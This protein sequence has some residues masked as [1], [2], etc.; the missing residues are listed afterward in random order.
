MPRRQIILANEEIYHVFNKGVADLP[1]FRDQYDYRRIIELVNFYRFQKPPSRYSFF[2]RLPKNTKNEI[3]S[4]LQKTNQQVKIFAFVLMPNHY[5][6]QLKQL[7]D[8]GISKFMGNLQNA[9]A[10]FF[11]TRHHKTGSLFQLRF[12][13]IRM[14][15]EEQ[16]LHLNRYIHLNP[17]TSYLIRKPEDLKTYQRS[18]YP[19]FFNSDQ[20]SFIDTDF[21]L[22]MFSNNRQNFSKFV[23]NQADYQRQLASIKHLILE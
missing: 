9:Y 22:K 8:N 6:F 16:L 12:K 10:R 23:L 14:E 20:Q 7:T 19:C 2:S 1:I 13:A 4:K 3:L 11:N 15:S 21:I 5:H 18:S 17:L